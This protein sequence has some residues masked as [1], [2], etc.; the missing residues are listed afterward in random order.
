MTATSREITTGILVAL[1]SGDAVSMDKLLG[2][3]YDELRHMARSQLAGER[4]DHTLQTTGLV[5][6]AY[7]R[8]VD[9]E[10]VAA[11]GRAY[12]FGAAARAMRQVLVDHARRRGAI[13]RGGDRV[14]ITLEDE[15]ASVDAFATDLLDLDEA[16]QRL[17]DDHERPARVVECRFFGGLTAE[18]TAAALDV[19]VRTVHYDWQFARAW[20]YRELA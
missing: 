4:P 1:E 8:L 3:V 12:F 9:D 20:L 11:R 17:A 13:R 5:H 6:E 14:G 19:S 2:V 15:H 18:E 10:R 7:L 16:L